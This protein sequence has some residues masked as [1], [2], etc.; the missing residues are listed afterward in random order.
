M[1]IALPFEE[2]VFEAGVVA[3]P[4]VGSLPLNGAGAGAGTGIGAGTGA[5]VATSP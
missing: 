2:L 4:A 3:L 1:P 5:G